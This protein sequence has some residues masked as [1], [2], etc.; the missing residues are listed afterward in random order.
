MSTEMMFKY[1]WFDRQH[2][3]VWPVRQSVDPMILGTCIQLLT[4]LTP[5]VMA[6]CAHATYVSHTAG[7]MLVILLS[8]AGLGHLA[9]MQTS[10][11]GPKLSL[12]Q[13]T[14]MTEVA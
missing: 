7:H 4:T 14:H 13:A 9:H 12:L 6:K 3:D 2:I 10:T 8:L 11:N 1:I 5:F